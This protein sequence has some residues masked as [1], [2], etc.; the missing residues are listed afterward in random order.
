MLLDSDTV[1]YSAITF[2]TKVRGNKC[3]HEDIAEF[4]FPT[5]NH[6]WSQT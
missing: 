5:S 2:P 4:V 1:V 6:V 3:D